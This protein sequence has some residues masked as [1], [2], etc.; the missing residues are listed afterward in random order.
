MKQVYLN[1][2]KNKIWFFIILAS[3]FFRNFTKLIRRLKEMHQINKK[4]KILQSLGRQLFNK[5]FETHKRK[6]S[7]GTHQKTRKRIWKNKFYFIIHYSFTSALILYL[8]FQ[9]YSDQEWN[10]LK[11][12]KLAVYQYQLMGITTNF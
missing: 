2:L 3:L 9:S 11:S 7:S 12:I 10:H 4:N 6:D 1:Y 8:C 5:L